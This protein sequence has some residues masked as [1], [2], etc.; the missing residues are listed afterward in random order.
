MQPYSKP[1]LTFAQQVALLQSRGLTIADTAAAESY[2]SQINYYRFSAYCPPFETARHKFR[3]GVTF[4]Q[5]QALYEFDRQ[6]R[7]VIYEALETA[8]N[9]TRTAMAYHLAHRYSDPFMHENPGNFYP[10]FNHRE[11]L[12]KV[13]AEAVRSHETFIEHYKNDYTGFPALPI[14]MAVEIMA[15]GSLSKLF[16]GLVRDDQIAIAKKFGIHSSVLVSWLHTMAYVRNICAHHSRLWNRELAIAMLLPKNAAW[17]SVN[18]RRIGAVIFALNN[19]I[20]KT[21]TAET[22]ADWRKKAESVFA[23]HPPPPNFYQSVGLPE[24]WK[25]DPLWKKP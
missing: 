22:T 4:G 16:A 1:P 18:S 8:E 25:E 24:N 3:P 13:H 2:L 20:P 23:V 14:W 5:V 9:I 15:F 11:W 21:S 17:R 12:D 7:V 6:L 19:V 10:G